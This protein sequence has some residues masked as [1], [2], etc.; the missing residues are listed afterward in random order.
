MHQDLKNKIRDL[1]PSIQSTLEDLIR[2]PSISAPI[3]DPSEVRRSAEKVAEL[4]SSH[5]F[6]N[7]RLLE[8]DGAH[9]AVFGE[10]PAPDGAPTVLLYAHHDVQPVGEGWTMDPFE[11]TVVDGRLYARGASDDKC[12][13][14]MHLAAV[15]AHDGRPP[16][17]VKVFA[18]GE[19]EIG[20]AHLGEYLERYGEQLSADVIVIADAG[21]WRVGVPAF[22]TSLRGLVDCTVE[23]ST[24]EAAV[25]SGMWGG[26]VI[27]ALTALS[28]LLATLHDEAGNVA[29]EGLVEADLDDLDLTEAEMRRTAGVL[30]GVELIGSG[31]LTDRMWAKPSLSVLAIDAPPVSAAINALIP[32]ARAKISL[33]IAPGQ[34]PTAAMDALTAHLEANAPWGAKVTVTK[35]AGGQAFHLD[36]SG[37]AYQAYGDAYEA[38]WGRPAVEMGVGGSIPFV[39]DF[40]AAY[41][42]AEIVLTG[43]ADMGSRAHG[44]DESLSLDDFEKACVAEAIALRLLA[45]GGS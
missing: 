39:A 8:V 33:R 44:P 26:T 20:S 41:P 21:N 30:D 9:P 22:T 45:E 17:G 13:V 14:A 34:D 28:R 6:E 29:I 3:G 5:H 25:H 24:L 35:G 1:F 42:N 12:G 43:A 31:S 15:A 10:I 19:E 32:T 40:S 7:V 16:V 4:L 11:P 27:D 38:A 23:V 36:T 37:P 18:E 2:I